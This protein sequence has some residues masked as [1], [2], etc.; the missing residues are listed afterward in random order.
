M[1][2][3]QNNPYRTIGLL[4]GATA[5]EQRRQL[6][7]L[8]RF[9]EAD[10]E[11]EGDFSFPTLG[12]IHRTLK[13]VNEASSKL[14]L[15]SDKMNAALFWFYKGNPITDEPAFDAIKEGDI[16]Q[17]INIWTKLTSNGEVSQRNASAYSNLGTLYLSGILEGTNTN[18]ALLEQGIYLKL[19]FLESDFIKDF[20][21]L[22]TDET[23]KATKKELQ[24][25]FLNQVQSEIEKS[26]EI[27]SNILLDI[28]TKE[29]FS[30][31]E[32]FFKGFVQKPIEQLEC[33]LNECKTHRKTKKEDVI[34]AGTNLYNAAR[35][36]LIQLK[37]ILGV[38]NIKFI[39]IAD[40]ISEE[41]LQCGIQLF[42]DYKDHK[43]YDPSE[44]AMK[45]FIKAKNFAVGNIAKQ[46]IEEN[47]ENLQE[48]IDDKPNRELN[49]KI[50]D[51]VEFIIEKL[52]LASDTLKNK[53]KY[54]KGYNDPY[55]DLPLNEQPH[56]KVISTQNKDFDSLLR[57]QMLLEHSSPFKT[58][59]YN[60]NLFRLARDTVKK[61][62]PKLD[63]IKTSVGSNNELYQK[64]SNDVASI[65]LACLIEYVNNSGNSALGIP[66]NIDEHEINV[67]NSIGE[68]EM[69][70]EMR[71]RY[72]DQKNAL[73]NL[74]R[75]VQRRSSSS[76]SSSSGCYIA[77]M[78]YG[79]YDH[80][81]VMILRQFR[82]E[83]LDKSVVGKWFIKTYYLYSPKLVEKLK[84]KRRI[85]AIIRKT[86]NQFIKLIK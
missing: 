36:I 35:P 67:M 77:T 6:T 52:N 17:V 7:R 71:K 18:E 58:N 79:D 68:L 83:V 21:T 53:G 23:F 22:A 63:S 26:E 20:K 66:P 62:K 69:N 14:N 49:K 73:A 13:S 27:S 31:K 37:G 34:V 54:P 24:L 1:H 82:D 80:P 44:P 57:T 76:S 81:Q 74:H 5:A 40:K 2:I 9:L 86:L 15:D 19:K 50:G 29:D 75:A 46:R 16:D 45:L 42:N 38:S 41:I 65:T 12:Q 59:E 30:A 85:N 8:Q 3:I 51:D 78:A 60:I 4:V 25:L 70:F 64:L 48:W 28:L 10:Q 11:P 72:N 55:S 47:T 43:T 39:S 56:N 32:D 61:C 84:N 33:L